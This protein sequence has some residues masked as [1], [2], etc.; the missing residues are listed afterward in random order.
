M[1]LRRKNVG[2]GGRMGGSHTRCTNDPL[3]GGMILG[4]G[5]GET[6]TLLL[7]L[8]YRRAATAGAR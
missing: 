4:N 7:C 5:G 3:G 1:T 6:G 2:R 8:Q